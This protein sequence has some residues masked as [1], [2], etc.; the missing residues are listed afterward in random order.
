[1]TTLV[2]HIIDGND[3]VDKREGVFVCCCAAFQQE[4]YTENVGT[5]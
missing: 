2:D 1:M 4:Q 5:C 3:S